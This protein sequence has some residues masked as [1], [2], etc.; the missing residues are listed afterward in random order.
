MV[1]KKVFSR[2]HILEAALKLIA[3]RGYYGVSIPDI[4]RVAG[5]ATGTIYRYFASKEALI[6]ELFIESKQLFRQYLFSNIQPGVSFEEVFFSVWKSMTLFAVQEPERLRFIAEHYHGSYLGQEAVEIVTQFEGE[7]QGV[8]E[9]FIKVQK[10]TAIDAESAISIV[11]G[12]FHEL[13]RKTGEINDQNRQRFE[14][15]GKTVFKLFVP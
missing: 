10:L 2:E 15:L 7:V 5:M 12:S 14:E 6:N 9:T 4:A 1:R 3:E 8:L 13:F 11:F